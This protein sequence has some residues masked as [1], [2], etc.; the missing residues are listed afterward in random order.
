MGGGGMEVPASKEVPTA[1]SLLGTNGTSLLLDAR[2]GH[3]GRPQARAIH[4]NV[5][6]PRL[7]I[8]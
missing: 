8:P 6:T 5:G 7:S 2:L 1:G 3:K 4:D